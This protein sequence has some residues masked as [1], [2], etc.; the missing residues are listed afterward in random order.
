MTYIKAFIMG[1]GKTT[2]SGYAIISTR[3]RIK[4]HLFLNTHFIAEMVYHSAFASRF[5][6]L[7][8]ITDARELMSRV[9]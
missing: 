5:N 6:R 4:G 8:V 7:R 2:L 9:V 1:T 3:R